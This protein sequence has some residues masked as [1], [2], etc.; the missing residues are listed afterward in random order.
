[1]TQRVLVLGAG[2][3]IGRRV[4][5]ALAASDWATVVGGYRRAPAQ[6][7]SGEHRIIEATDE[8]QLKLALHDIDAVVNCVAGNRAVIVDGARALFRAAIAQ[9]RPPRIVHLS[10]MSVYGI[11]TGVTD[12]SGEL[13]EDLGHYSA[14]K[15]EAERLAAAYPGVVTLRPSCVFGPGSPQWS[16]RIAQW[17]MTHRIGD[18][19][20]AG[21]G[22]ANLLYIDDLVAAILAALRTPGIE[23]Q[24]F[25]LSIADP[26]TWNDYF[27][28]FAIALGAVPIRRVSKR[29][30]DFET[31]VLAP[32]LQLASLALRSLGLRRPRLPAPMPPSLLHLWRKEVRVDGRKAQRLMAL[33]TTPLDQAL[34]ATA[35]W[36]N[37][38]RTGMPA[39]PAGD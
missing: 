8:A 12:E 35:G 31:R 27:L 36:F 15:I 39:G 1:M 2:G 3:F 17:L 4:T 33:E 30:L 7:G 16:G 5:A 11:A 22:V 10:S 28:R 13:S 18:L 32:P 20:S 6:A 34:R 37:A 29:R 38:T 26:P 21:D 19:G 23:G 24:A 14:A 9:A 25:N